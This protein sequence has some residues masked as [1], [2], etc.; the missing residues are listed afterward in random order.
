MSL[1][2]ATDITFTINLINNDHHW[3]NTNTSMLLGDFITSLLYVECPSNEQCI[4]CG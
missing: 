1:N 4:P 3:K 2:L